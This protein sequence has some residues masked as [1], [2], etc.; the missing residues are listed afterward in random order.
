MG[1]INEDYY[2]ASFGHY[3]GL[4]L[5]EEASDYIENYNMNNIANEIEE[6]K[7]INSIK[8]LVGELRDVAS[9]SR[10]KYL[11]INLSN[12]ELSFKKEDLNSLLKFIEVDRSIYRDYEE[13]LNIY[14]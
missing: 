11:L 5:S 10:A 3:M 9:V 13:L 4:T 14:I 7:K 1:V 2:K 12:A 6:V 8:E